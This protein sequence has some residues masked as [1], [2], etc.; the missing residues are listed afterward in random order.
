MLTSKLNFNKL[1]NEEICL[2]SGELIL[3]Q[4]GAFY[5]APIGNNA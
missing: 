1:V 2:R 4:L 5:K 3:I